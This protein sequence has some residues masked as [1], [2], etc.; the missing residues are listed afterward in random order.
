MLHTALVNIGQNRI[1]TTEGHECRLREK[2]AHL[3]E[4][5]LPAK[6][7]KQYRHRAEPDE[8]ADSSIGNY[9]RPSEPRMLGR[10]RMIINQRRTVTLLTVTVMT[11]RLEL[12]RCDAPT[13]ITNHAGCQHDIRE[14]H[15]QSEDRHE[16]HRRHGPE[17]AILQCA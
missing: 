1:R 2:P 5:A 14:W 7:Y 13:K 12:F 17:H 3:R 4:P 6:L 10:W 9:A 8:K 15:V 11:S 16:R